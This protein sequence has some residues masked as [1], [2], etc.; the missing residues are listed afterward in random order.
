[1]I[2]I[3]KHFRNFAPARLDQ[4]A[5]KNFEKE[6]TLKIDEHGL[7]VFVA[8]LS[9]A[10]AEHL[11]GWPDVNVAR[12]ILLGPQPFHRQNEIARDAGVIPRPK[13]FMR[14]G[15]RTPLHNHAAAAQPRHMRRH[16]ELKRMKTER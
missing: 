2:G 13:F 10:A 7:G 5:M 15:P 12:P 3:G 1:M 4:P 8:S 11:L 14:D 9:A 6:V 16:P